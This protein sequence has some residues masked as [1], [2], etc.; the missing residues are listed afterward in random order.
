MVSS[1]PLLSFAL[2]VSEKEYTDKKNYKASCKIFRIGVNTDLQH[3]Y[4]RI[5]ISRLMGD[6]ANQSDSKNDPKI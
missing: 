6:Y 5:N 1:F 4:Y 2:S 3:F